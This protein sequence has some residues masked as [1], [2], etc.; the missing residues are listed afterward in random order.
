MTHLSRAEAKNQDHISLN[1]EDIEK[2]LIRNW[3]TAENEVSECWF[4]DNKKTQ[5]RTVPEQS[6]TITY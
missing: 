3:F 1:N 5:V 2:K 6:H 4:A